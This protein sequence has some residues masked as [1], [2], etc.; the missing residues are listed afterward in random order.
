MYDSI[1]KFLYFR[2]K[3]REMLLLTFIFITLNSVLN[4]VYNI[5][6]FSFINR[7]T[8]NH[9]IYFYNK[10]FLFKKKK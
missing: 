6:I 10:D 4:K 5:S 8:K 2:E 3:Y 9:Q 1:I 7:R